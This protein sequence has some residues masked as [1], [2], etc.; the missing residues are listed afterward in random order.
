MPIGHP[1]SHRELPLQV[2]LAADKELAVFISSI[3]SACCAFRDELIA[4]R[5]AQELM[6]ALVESEEVG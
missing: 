2:I 4:K 5:A 3:R 6:L 1:G